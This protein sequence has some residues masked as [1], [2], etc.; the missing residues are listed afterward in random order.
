PGAATSI[1]KSSFVSNTF[2]AGNVAP[3]ILQLASEE[4]SQSLVKKSS[5]NEGI[6]GKKDPFD[7]TRL[8]IVQLLLSRFWLN[9]LALIEIAISR[10]HFSISVPDAKR[11]ISRTF[12]ALLVKGWQ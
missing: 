12:L 8:F 5:N 6:A 9:M 4:S 3:E 10:T 7:L 11:R 1:L 2:T